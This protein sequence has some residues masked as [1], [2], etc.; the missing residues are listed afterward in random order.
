ESHDVF[1]TVAV[2]VSQQPDV[3]VNAPTLVVAEVC[4]DQGR[5]PKTRL[6]RARAENARVAEADHVFQPVAVDVARQ[7]HLLLYRPA[8]VVAEVREHGGRAEAR[9]GGSRAPHAVVAKSDDVLLAVTVG[10]GE[11]ARL[12]IIGAIAEAQRLSPHLR[13]EERLFL[14]LPQFV[15]EAG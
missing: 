15:G 13:R 6:G 3:A 7:T 14:P 12:L 5:W 8:L 4:D 2:H 11:Q 1:F 10:V 9:A